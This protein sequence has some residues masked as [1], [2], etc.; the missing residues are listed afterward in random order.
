MLGEYNELYLDLS[1][2]QIARQ[3][4]LN[5][6]IASETEIDVCCNEMLC[7]STV[8]VYWLMLGSIWPSTKGKFFAKI[9]TMYFT[10][11]V[12]P[13]NEWHIYQYSYAFGTCKNQARS[14]I[15]FATDWRAS[16][17]VHRVNKITW[18]RKWRFMQGFV[19]ILKPW[20]YDIP[21]TNL[22]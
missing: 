10:K 4:D 15:K 12:T 5:I 9:C 20:R 22:K 19:H 3:F 2:I 16:R 21:A 8:T 1:A 11:A 7:W 6:L 18:N 14:K 17:L 13:I